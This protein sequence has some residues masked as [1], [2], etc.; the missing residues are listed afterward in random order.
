MPIDVTSSRSLV[1]DVPDI[2]TLLLVEGRYQN[3]IKP[4]IYLEYLQIPWQYAVLDKVAAAAEWFRQIHPLLYVP[5]LIDNVDDER[6][7]LW[8][9]S[10][11]LSYLG[12]RYDKQKQLVGRTMRENAEISSWLTFETASIGPSAKYWVWYDMR[13]GDDVNKKAQDKMMVDLQKQYG[14]LN[15]RLLEPGQKWIALK[16]RPTIADIAILPFTD[17]NTFGR[18]QVDIETWPALADWYRRMMALPYVK[19]AYE[20][21]ESRK[22]KPIV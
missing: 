11:I 8:D 5:A 2:P 22:E 6:L 18:M 12:E 9:S 20:E 17:W 10:A 15:Q 14:I 21:R 3:W 16:D 13:T 1:E 19:K 4:V 7:V